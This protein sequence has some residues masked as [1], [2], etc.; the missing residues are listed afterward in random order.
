MALVFTVYELATGR[1]LRSMEV[2]DMDGAMLNIDPN[3]EGTIAGWFDP[4]LKYRRPDG[5]LAYYPPRPSEHHVFDYAAEQWIDPRS[6]E[7][8]AAQEDAALQAQREGMVL[9]FAQFLIGLVRLGWITEA[10]GE[11][12]LDGTLPPVIV[13]M[14]NQ[15]PP[16]HRFAVM[17]RAKRPERVMRN[18]PVV[19]SLAQIT[20]R[21]PEQVDDLFRTYSTI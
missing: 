6:P 9:G 1:L 20:G 13:Q 3:T 4:A 8:V 7:Q 16:H 21:T 5:S 2:P 10:E 12:W 14:I 19:L 17:A 18:D 15:L 11:A